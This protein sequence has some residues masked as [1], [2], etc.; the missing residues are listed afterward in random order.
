MAAATAVETAGDAH[1]Y[2]GS[3]ETT[4]AQLAVATAKEGSDTL[5]DVDAIAAVEKQRT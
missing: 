4:A 1:S 5:G 3:A 2:S